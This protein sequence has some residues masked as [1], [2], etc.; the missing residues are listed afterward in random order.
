MANEKLNLEKLQEI[1]FWQQLNKQLLTIKKRHAAVRNSDFKSLQNFCFANLVFSKIN[2]SLAGNELPLSLITD[3]KNLFIITL[4][5]SA[6]TQICLS[7]FPRSFYLDIESALADS[8]DEIKKYDRKHH[9]IMDTDQNYD[10]DNELSDFVA[11][12]IDEKDRAQIDVSSMVAELYVLKAKALKKILNISE[13]NRLVKVTADSCLLDFRSLRKQE[14]IIKMYEKVCNI[15]RNEFIAK[16]DP[17][18]E[19]LSILTNL[20]NATVVGLL[21][22]KLKEPALKKSIKEFAK[23]ELKKCKMEV[24][25]IYDFSEAV[26]KTN[27]SNLSIINIGSTKPFFFLNHPFPLI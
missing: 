1:S 25:M 3:L 24:K 26:K 6:W 17:I 19:P 23:H 21:E 13:I 8:L 20:A 10:D 18:I 4:N 9:I 5:D 15:Y 14:T 2:G 11:S 27:P 12:Y 7:V 22:H 16:V